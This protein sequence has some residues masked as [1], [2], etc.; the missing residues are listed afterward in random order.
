MLNLEAAS[1][2]PEPTIRRAVIVAGALR[3]EAQALRA[4]FLPGTRGPLSVRHDCCLASA[5][6]LEAAARAGRVEWAANE[7]TAVVAVEAWARQTA[8]A[9]ASPAPRAGLPLRRATLA[10]PPP[11]PGEYGPAL[12]RRFAAERREAAR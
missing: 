7:L 3:R 5:A 6:G 12:L 11:E 8:P 2:S 10:A 4:R 9:A 1:K